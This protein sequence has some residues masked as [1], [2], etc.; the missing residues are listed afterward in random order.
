MRSILLLLAAGVIFGLGGTMDVSAQES[1]TILELLSKAID[2]TSCGDGIGRTYR[3]DTFISAVEHNDVENFY[4]RHEA[5]AGMSGAAAALGVV[6]LP[7]GFSSRCSAPIE[8]PGVDYEWVIC[9][10]R[11]ASKEALIAPIRI[12]L[13]EFFLIT[14]DDQKLASYTNPDLYVGQRKDI[15][16]GIDFTGPEPVFGT[17]AFPAYPGQVDGPF[18]L[19]WETS[20]NYIIAD[21]LEPNVADAFL[22]DMGFR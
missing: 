5:C 22:Y 9:S 3:G 18:V 13:D 17:I 21:E 1:D 16:D 2:D 4:A 7:V 19:S 10:L 8:I 14:D 20:G 11:F 6:P 12:D 15:S